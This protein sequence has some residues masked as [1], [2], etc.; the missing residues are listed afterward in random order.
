MTASLPLRSAWRWRVFTR[1]FRRWM[2]KS[3][4]AVRLS[5][6]GWPPL[7]DGRPV[8]VV[9]NHPSWW[10]PLLG[11]I[12]ADLFAGY[13]HYAPIDAAAL[14]RYRILEPMGFFGVE[15]GSAE[16]ALR[17]LRTSTAVLS[18]PDNCLW[19]TA[20]GRITDPRERPVQLRQGVAHL[21]RRL[22]GVTVLPLAIE[23]PFWQERYPEAL[24]H[25]GEPIVADRGRDRSVAEW[26]GCIEAG[27][28]IAQDE[29]ARVALTQNP[30]LFETLV[31]GNTGIGGVYDLWRR[32]KAL[33]RGQRFS[34]SHGAGE[35]S[36]G[37]NS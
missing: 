29:L 23:Y 2:G 8:V 37:G 25:F 32:L 28:T 22:D 30:E 26:M 20:Q 15:V 36:P 11:M 6:T 35:L 19:I 27:L 4:H 5:R 34:G 9:L 33:V 16:G 31:G 14:K 10:D 13:R 7:L 17:F 21:L 12:L 1:Y 3:F 24:A 18:Q